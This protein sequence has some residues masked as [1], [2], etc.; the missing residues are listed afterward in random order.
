MLINITWNKLMKKPKHLKKKYSK[1]RKNKKSQ[2]NHYPSNVSTGQWRAIRHLFPQ[3]KHG[4]PRIWHYKGILNAIFY[5]LKTGCAWRFLPY[6]FPPWELVYG[7]FRRWS[8]SGFIERIHNILRDRLR[9]SVGRNKSP[10]T[11]I[12]DSQ[13]AKTTEQGGSRGY[14][15]G[16]KINGRKRH[17]IVDCLGLIL[18]VHIHPANIQDRDGAKETLLKIKGLYPLLNLMWADGGYRGELIEWVNQHFD[19]KLE[20]V[21]RND[22]VK[23]FEVLPWRWIV[24]RTLAWISRNRRMSKDYERLSKTT[25]SW[26]YL[27]MTSL[28]LKRLEKIE[29]SKIAE[30]AA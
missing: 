14:D 28:M 19:I 1:N 7:Y 15:A 29:E 17:I 5:I 26:I 3:Y 22:D 9:K 13:S 25:E 8:L 11:A 20:I 16:K 6:E 4:R 27:A 21:K 23:E 18:A 2:K 12:I 10:S 30:I 24:E